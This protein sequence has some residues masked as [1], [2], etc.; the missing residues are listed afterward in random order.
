M[1][2]YTKLTN[3][4]TATCQKKKQYLADEKCKA[5]YEGNI[6][7]KKKQHWKVS[8]VQVHYKAT[9]KEIGG[10]IEVNPMLR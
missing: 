8:F 2:G 6:K 3:Q 5:R 10:S 7:K 9:I 1:C 4:A